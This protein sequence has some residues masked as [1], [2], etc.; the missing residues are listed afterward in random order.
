MNIIPQI[1]TYPSVVGFCQTAPGK[2]AIVASFGTA[3][4]LNRVDAW[5]SLTL[6]AGSATFLPERRKFILAVGAL[7]WLIFHH[8]WSQT[9]LI[10]QIAGAEGIRTDWILTLAAGGML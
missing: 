7:Y 4:A 10:R 1:D 2:L 5:P 3:L 6:I 8:I 9:D